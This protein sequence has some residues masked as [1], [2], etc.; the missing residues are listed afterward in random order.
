VW[1]LFSPILDP[2]SFDLGSGQGSTE[3][4]PDAPCHVLDSKLSVDFAG[5]NAAFAHIGSTVQVRRHRINDQVLRYFSTVLHFC[6]Y[7]RILLKFRAY[8][9]IVSNRRIIITCVHSPRRIGPSN[10]QDAQASES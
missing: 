10:Y 5:T 2:P 4:N 3:S 6:I 7:L 1:S 8:L 9:A